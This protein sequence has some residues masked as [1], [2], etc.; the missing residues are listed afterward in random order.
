MSP[1]PD[2]LPALCVPVLLQQRG[3][4]E[5]VRG[6]SR[7]LIKRNVFFNVFT[8][9]ICNRCAIHAN[10]IV[11]SCRRRR[12]MRAFCRSVL[13]FCPSSFSSHL[14]LALLQLRS[15]VVGAPL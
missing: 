15:V 8:L 6:Q 13:G 7:L 2:P 5:R 12:A 9:P 11:V 4:R 10:V 14:L 3:E 1:H